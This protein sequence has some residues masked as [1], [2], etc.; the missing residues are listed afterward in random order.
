MNYLPHPT[1]SRRPKQ[2]R[3]TALLAGLMQIKLPTSKIL[4][5]QPPCAS[6]DQFFD[7]MYATLVP[8]C[9]AD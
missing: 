4:D 3:M 2:L 1:L 5:C 7:I 6:A 9:A 8:Q